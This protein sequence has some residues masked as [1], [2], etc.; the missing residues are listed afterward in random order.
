MKAMISACGLLALMIATAAFGQDIHY[1]FDKDTDFSK[2]R[3]YKWV[4]IKGA[5]K[6]D[7]ITDKQIRAAVDAGLGEK[8]LTKVEDDNADVLVGYQTAVGEDKQ[9]TSYSTGWGYGPGWYRGGWYGPTGGMTTGTT[10][11]IYTGQLALDMYSPAGHDLIWRGVA[12]KTIDP[13]AKPEKREK[14]LNKAID[15]LLKDYPP[16]EKK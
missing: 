8:G 7:S 11:T 5:Q 12:T 6:A 3:T 1:N 13:K 16:E 2:I 15:K 9:F 10:S 4:D 14:N